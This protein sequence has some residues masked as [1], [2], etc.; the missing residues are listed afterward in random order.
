VGR[1]RN[2]FYWWEMIHNEPSSPPLLNSKGLYW[3]GKHM[4]TLPKQMK[5]INK[6]ELNSKTT[7][8]NFSPPPLA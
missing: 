5:W 2:P 8:M 3:H 4:F 6:C 7:K 1:E